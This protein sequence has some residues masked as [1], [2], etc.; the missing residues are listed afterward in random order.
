MKEYV[1]YL[2]A[3]FWGLVDL[4]TEKQEL[5]GYRLWTPE[6]LDSRVVPEALDCWASSPEAS[7]CRLTLPLP[8]NCKS[9][10]TA[11]IH[12]DSQTKDLQVP[13]LRNR[14]SEKQQTDI[15][16]QQ[17]CGQSLQSWY[18][19]VSAACHGYALK[20]GPLTL[21]GGQV[22]AAWNQ[23]CLKDPSTVKY[24]GDVIGGFT[25]VESIEDMPQDEICSYCWLEHYYAM[26]RSRYFHY[27]D[28]LGSEIAYTRQ[29][30]G[31]G[32]N[33]TI[34][35][36]NIFSCPPRLRCYNGGHY[37]A[38]AGDT[39]ASIARE[40]SLSAVSLYQFNP[41]GIRD[42]EDIP[43][44]TQLCVPEGC[45]DIYDDCTF[46]EMNWTD[47]WEVWPEDPVPEFNRWVKEGC[48]PLNFVS[49][50]LEHYVCLSTRDGPFASR[51][52]E[53]NDA[54]QR[55]RTS[56][57][58]DHIAP[59]PA[60][61]TVAQDTTRKCGVW[62]VAAADGSDDCELIAYGSGT[63]MQIFRKAN[64]SLGRV[65]LECNSRLVPGQAYCAVPFLR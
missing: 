47:A 12:C 29:R 54:A 32:E 13:G 65:T 52:P 40:N 34:P 10:L 2:L 64:P 53:L 9:A 4:P 41:H 3:W 44:G 28:F 58:A 49:N 18:D 7:N 35:D 55:N 14:H 15:V 56:G 33:A 39:C 21:R 62:H 25:S 27:G 8:E 50:I 1:L 45:E 36:Y 26:Q 42:C 19:S 63:T 61:V 43:E 22:W 48:G 30:C 31:T 16:C 23:T 37:T 59:P 6:S 5:D 17:S 24:C 46:L 20:D 51:S 60:G 57:W 11:L 38:K